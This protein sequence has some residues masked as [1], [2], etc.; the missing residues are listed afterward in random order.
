LRGAEI[1]LGPDGL[2]L[3][4]F[5][6]FAL[7]RL[8]SRRTG[9]N[10]HDAWVIAAGA[11]LTMWFHRS[12][13]GSPRRSACHSPTAKA[14][15]VPRVLVLAIGTRLAVGALSTGPTLMLKAHQ[16]GRPIAAARITAGLSTVLRAAAAAVW[17]GIIAILIYFDHCVD[18]VDTHCYSKATPT[19]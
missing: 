18:R 2:A 13:S 10:T 1:V 8:S 16:R 17:A 19:N 3:V 4:A 11:G 9:T 15:E 14:L 12:F 6:V 5:N 7:P